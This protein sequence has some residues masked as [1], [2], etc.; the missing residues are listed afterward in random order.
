MKST[1]NLWLLIIYILIST[2]I[3][4]QNLHSGNNHAIENG[5]KERQEN[6]TSFTTE[7]KG[8][9][10]D[11]KRFNSPAYYKHP[12]FGIL[13][14]NAPCSECVEDLSKR[15]SNVRYFVDLK[16]PAQFYQQQSMGDMNVY[17]DG[18]YL[19]KDVRLKPRGNAIYETKGSYYPVGI[20]ITRKTT[21]IITE[22]GRIYFNNWSL[23]GEKNGAKEVL[24]QTKWDDYTIG[25]DG[26][27]I[28]D[29]FPGIDA[30]VLVN[31][32]SL[33][34]NYI[35][36]RNDF[37]SYDKLIFRDQFGQN[38]QY[39]ITSKNA[40][41]GGQKLFLYKEGIELLQIDEAFAYIEK[42]DRGNRKMLDY[43]VNRQAFDIV[44]P[45]EW[46]NEQLTHS[47][48]IIDPLVTSSATLA[49]ASIT[50]SQ[51]N[52]SCNFTNS[53]DYTVNVNT[54]ANSTVTD[55]QV[56]FT[57]RAAL[58]S[59]CY[60]IDGGTRF[61]V[62]SC[63]T[64]SA[65]GFYYFCPNNSWGTCALTNQTIYSEL[66]SCLPAPSCTPQSVPVTL[67]FYRSCFGGNSCN[68]SCIGA[69][70][71]FIVTLVGRTLEYSNTTTPITSATTV[72]AGQSLTMST[73]AAYGVPPYTYN[74]SFNAS[75]TPS[76]GTGNS[77][78]ITF[79]TVG[80]QTVYSVIT[81][82]C[83]TTQTSSVVVNVTASPEGVAT[84]SSATICSGGTTN[85][86]LSAVPAATS[87]TWTAAS[88]GVTGASDGTGALIAQTLTSTTGGT[89][90][91]TITPNGS[92]PGVPFTV[93]VTV[94]PPSTATAGGNSPVCEGSSINLTANT[95]AGATYSWTG[96]NSFTSSS[97]NPVISGATPAMSG[98]Y[99]LALTSPG[100]SPVTSTVNITVITAP[101]AT[102]GSNSP[103]CEGSSINLT[104]NTIAGATYSWTG[105]NGYTSGTQNPT[106]TG[107]TAAAAGTY[108]LTITIPGCTPVTSTVNVVVN[109]GPIATAGSNSPVCE[110]SSINLTANT[111]IGASYGWTGPNGYTSSSQ[112]PTITGTTPAMS[113]TYTLTITIP[114]CSPVTSTVNVV[115]NAVPTATAGSNSPVC[116]GSS[117]NLTA[118]TVAGASYGWTGPNGYTSGSQNPTIPNS[119]A[120]MAGTYTLTIT[121]PGCTPATST[122]NVVVNP[123]PT[124]TAGGNS[125]VCEGAPINLTANTV[126]GATYD[127]T[128][129]NGYTSSSQNPTITGST[130]AA[131]GTYTLT[132]TITG[133]SPITSTVNI[134]V[135]PGP[136]AT[137]GSNSPVCAGS[138][139]NLTAN[140]ITGAIYSWTG[141]NGFTSSLQN[142]TIPNSTA[143]MAGTYTLTATVAGCSPV[144]SSTT[145]V[146]NSL[147]VLT[148]TKTDVS[149]FGGNSGTATVNAGTGTYTYQW[150]PSGGTAA[151]ASSLTAGTY[152]VAVT[153]AQG[154]V[155]TISVVITQP[156][157]LVSTI[158]AVPASCNGNTGSATV[159]ANGGTPPYTYTWTPS[160]G[161]ANT[162]SNLAA[163]NYSVLVT[164]SKGCTSSNSVQVTSS[165]GLSITVANQQSVSC[166]GATDGS[167]TITVSGGSGT[168]TYL[169]SP[170]GAT[171]PTAGNLSPGLYN[172]S[173][174]DNT[175]C[176]ANQTITITAPPAIQLQFDGTNATCGNSDGSVTV[177]G[178]GGTGTITYLWGHDNSNTASVINIP[179]GSY[180]VD[181]TDANGCTIT[182][183]YTLSQTGGL[184]IQINPVNPVIY[185]DETVNLN[186]TL[187]PYVPGIIYTWTPPGSLSCNNCPNPVASPD[188][189]TT[190]TV[191]ITTPTGCTDS[192]NTTVYVK[193]R[194]GEVHIPSIFSPN[195][196]GNNDHFIVQG[197]CVRAYGLE[198]F[199]RWGEKI[200]DN[201]DETTGW[202]GTH[203]GKELNTGTYVYSVKVSY[204]DGTYENFK[205]N[206]ALVR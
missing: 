3:T 16:N 98:T 29:V 38:D 68:N 78:S 123:G 150:S 118:N 116:E 65:A 73:S 191:I 204:L 155:S 43:E 58:F 124:A 156:A 157:Q 82:A 91:Y 133:C 25:E 63:V 134:V 125:P 87:Y 120:A 127:W 190:Y 41:E 10:E 17:K 5:M 64:P 101:T 86:A 103:V 51:Y 110:G 122:V 137:A 85:I 179:A 167:A 59:L 131:A 162:A 161:T 159:T 21:Y 97:Q 203:K 90:T 39:N 48:V 69:D 2:N 31:D 114:G 178:S 129:P 184:N 164:D 61:S 83:G 62:G 117:I 138:T 200:Y 171:T 197:R 170:G 40:D 66:A 24:A 183:N 149:C 115:V 199:N 186:A 205:G 139:L 132:L 52:A 81:D 42:G 105:P 108:T 152:S 151:T 143:A 47:R 56:S 166:P 80:T 148:S 11:W 104:A 175:G 35:V 79:P 28:Y 34:T 113:G 77:Q 9:P 181:A 76:L 121:I 14:Y 176:S 189:T 84:P 153:S 130:P 169:W 13:A 102:A 173:V 111:I 168:Y 15:S 193:M 53:C 67:K 30:E 144:S 185:E 106:I 75:G 177:L 92:C 20:D 128:G 172:V 158:T 44:V 4:A 188:T 33:K 27:Y 32:G 8:N 187:T 6:L 136:T 88:S 182:G 100:C 196:D 154:C 36:K 163:G 140:S 96:P 89:V 7:K 1:N 60:L 50:G 12:E 198:I 55:L 126:A 145:V 202:D 19:I 99:T 160:G 23:L 142:P 46:L 49:Q 192:L 94:N 45:A 54:P 119:T 70:S 107:S 26:I 165:A 180:T 72:C 195:G 71:P 95:I 206:F 93:V 146:V 112:N 74:W 135:N 201:A 37:V 109:P 18:H 141:P 147:P 22:K 57:Y 174:T 194:C